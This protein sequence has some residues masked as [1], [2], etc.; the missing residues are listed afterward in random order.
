MSWRAPAARARRRRAAP[1]RR[2]RAVSQ[3]RGPACGRRS[4]ERLAPRLGGRPVD[5]QHAVE[6]VE[7]VLGDPRR[8]PSSSSRISLALGVGGLDRHP[9][10]A[11]RPGPRRPAATGSPRRRPRCSS[12]ALGE[13]RV[14]ERQRL[15]LRV[16]LEDEDP[17]QHADL[18]R[19][20]ADAVRV[21]QQVLHPLDRAGRSS[22]KV[23]DVV[24]LHAQDRVGVLADLREREP[25][26]RLGLGVELLCLDLSGLVRH[27]RCIVVALEGSADRRR[28][29]RSGPPGA[30][31][32]RRPRAAA[33]RGRRGAAAR[34]SSR[35]A[36]PGDG[37]AGGSSGAGPSSSPAPSSPA[38]SSSSSAA[39]SS[40]SERPETS[41]RTRCRKGG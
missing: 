16:G 15:L 12:E 34:P 27:R 28:R 25:P 1:S 6:V 39:A 10:V 3:R 13:P 14:D 33:P 37:R 2:R 35:R 11:A 17:S 9:F 29:P 32:A 20:E 31:P 40:R 7:L 18:R 21:V 23:L 4:R 19:G 5:D 30:S 41:T 8:E 26:P 22:S 24:R 38:R 36:G